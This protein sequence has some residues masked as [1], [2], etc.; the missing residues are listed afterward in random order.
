MRLADAG[1]ARARPLARAAVAAD[2]GSLEPVV[3]ATG[4]MVLYFDPVEDPAPIKRVWCLFEVLT[5]VTTP[6]GELSACVLCR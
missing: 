4:R 1:L 6:G 5:L 2:L 3:R